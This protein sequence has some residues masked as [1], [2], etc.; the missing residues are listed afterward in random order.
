MSN[1]N[2][3]FSDSPVA[4]KS[5]PWGCLFG[6]CL[7]VF[8]LVVLGISAS[9]Y[10]G[11]RYYKSQLDAYT[12]TQPVEIQSV[13]Y[14]DQEIASVKQRVEDFTKALEKGDAPEQ[15]VLTADEINAFISSQKELKGKLFVKIEDGEIKGEASFPVPKVIPL[16]KGRYFNGSM[17][18]RAS[19]ENGVLIVTIDEAEVN[20]KPVPDEIMDSM[21]NENLA[22]DAYK[23][24]QTAEFL[25]KFERL[26]IEDN[27]IILTPAKKLDEAKPEDSERKDDP[28]EVPAETPAEVSSAEELK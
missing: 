27:R 16:S 14:T 18:L 4:E 13:E 1:S 9:F 15:L 28:A 8:L 2:S 10:A 12:S 20:G 6:G 7:T 11:Y 23:D 19:L 25:K 22:K 24:P 26:T 5:F 17:S 3:T 21:R